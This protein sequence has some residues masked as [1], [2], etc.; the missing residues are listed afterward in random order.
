MFKVQ[1]VT[2]TAD[3]SYSTSNLAV[4]TESLTNTAYYFLGTRKDSRKWE[5]R[6]QKVRKDRKVS[7]KYTRFFPQIVA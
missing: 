2:G 7:L 4:L 3:G 5:L 1:R 6:L